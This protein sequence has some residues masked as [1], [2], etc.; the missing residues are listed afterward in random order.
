MAYTIKIEELRLLCNRLLDIAEKNGLVGI[1]IEGEFQ[2]KIIDVDA[3]HSLNIIESKTMNDIEG[4]YNKLYNQSPMQ[5]TDFSKIANLLMIVHD[6]ISNSEMVY[7]DYDY[8][9][10]QEYVEDLDEFQIKSET[11]NVE[12]FNKCLNAL[13]SNITIFDQSNEK[14]EIR[15]KVRQEFP[16]TEEDKIDWDK[17][18]FKMEF[19]LADYDKNSIS[20]LILEKTK[21]LDAA[22]Y[23]V[24][25]N[26]D[27]F[28]PKIRTDLLNALSA[29]SLIQDVDIFSW[30]ICFEQKYII[31]TNYDNEITIGFF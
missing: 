21:T 9:D 17:T 10:R 25:N 20:S 16:A 29:L 13:G 8:S 5:I 19:N 18:I 7:A 28:Y 6:V 22:V 23:I 14:S 12:G 27:L 30:I 24:W 31:K 15:N 2:Y 3:N 26:C 1:E 11:N 4:F